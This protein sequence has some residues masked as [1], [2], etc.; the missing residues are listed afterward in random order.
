MGELGFYPTGHKIDY[1]G[2]VVV[3]ENYC[4]LGCVSEKQT[5]GVCGAGFYRPDPLPVM[6][7]TVSLH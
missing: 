4:R 1:F 6:Q 2:D 5:S 7:L 3:F